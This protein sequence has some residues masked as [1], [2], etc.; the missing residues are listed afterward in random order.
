MSEICEDWRV[1]ARRVPQ[2]EYLVWEWCG[3]FGVYRPE[4]DLFY[5][6]RNRGPIST[7]QGRGEDGVICLYARARPIIKQR[8]AA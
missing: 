6:Q 8:T 7:V 2:N 3:A 1:V 4:L 5:S